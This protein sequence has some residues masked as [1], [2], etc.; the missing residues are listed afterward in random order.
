MNAR[1]RPWVGLSR[2]T[3]PAAFTLVELLVVIGIIALLISIL[4]PALGKAKDE[5]NRA[6]CSSNLRQAGIGFR[7]YAADNKDYIPWRALA[8]PGTSPAKYA[9]IVTVG[10]DSGYNG[11]TEQSFGLALLLTPPYGVGRNYRPNNDVFFCPSDDV[12]APF[13]NSTTRWGPVLISGG[14]QSASIWTRYYPKRAWNRAITFPPVYVETSGDFVN[15]KFSARNATQRAIL[16]D[17]GVPRFSWTTGT[18]A[19]TADTYPAFHAKLKGV[20]V[21]YLDGHVAFI[22]DK[23]VARFNQPGQ[24]GGGYEILSAMIRAYN[25]PN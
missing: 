21:L 20:N 3:G 5:A 8:L 14:G 25:S 22:S 15:E 2:G 11:A 7:L 6:K 12:R 10:S 16:S 19:T 4:L 24:P 9:P 17:Q 18:D 23:Q 13:R 1:T